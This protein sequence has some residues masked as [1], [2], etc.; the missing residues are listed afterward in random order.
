MPSIST[1]TLLVISP[2]MN[3]VSVVR[4]GLTGH[5]ALRSPVRQHCI[6]HRI[7]DTVAD[8]V[9]MTLGHNS[10]VNSFLMP[11]PPQHSSCLPARGDI[12][13][14]RLQESHQLIQT[15]AHHNGLFPVDRERDRSPR[16]AGKAYC[17]LP[18]P[19]FRCQ[20]VCH[21]PPQR[22]SRLRSPSSAPR[23]GCRDT[24][25]GTFTTWPIRGFLFSSMCSPFSE[26][27]VIIIG[28]RAEIIVRGFRQRLRVEPLSFLDS[29]KKT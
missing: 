15:D 19:C 22:W 26:R 27:D 28:Q 11:F 8:L 9:G 13:R 4:A 16:I 17:I 18:Y 10:D 25:A 2:A 6:Q 7:R 20:P 14:D 21:R 29:P 12:Q 5:P 23:Q 24:C 3:T 1:S